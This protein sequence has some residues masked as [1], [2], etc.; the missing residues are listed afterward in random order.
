MQVI[1]MLKHLMLR[2]LL[3]LI[4]YLIYLVILSLLNKVLSFTCFSEN[5]SIGIILF[6]PVFS[7]IFLL[8]ILILY[9]ILGIQF[10]K[11]KRIL[12]NILMCFIL[13]I[14][15]AFMLDK[16]YGDD[17]FN[18]VSTQELILG[19]IG[20]LLVIAFHIGILTWLTKNR[21]L[22]KHIGLVQ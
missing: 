4:V 19:T 14:V 17:I 8:P 2:I 9:F 12:I 16:T 20:A 7:I 5:K 22:R 11:K 18:K 6:S 1:L 3:S 10:Y 13:Y 21:I 15:T